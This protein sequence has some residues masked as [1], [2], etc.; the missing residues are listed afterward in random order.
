MS[1]H[2]NHYEPTGSLTISR[3]IITAFT[4]MTFFTAIPLVSAVYESHLLKINMD[5]GIVGKWFIFWAVAVRFLVTGFLQVLRQG[6]GRSVVLTQSNSGQNMAKM[7]GLVKMFLAG[8]AFLCVVKGSGSLLAAI[9]AGIY[10]GLAAFQH[11]FKRPATIEGWIEMIFDM[12]VFIVISCC[13]V[14]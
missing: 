11:D 7:E 13:L 14:F 6:K 10:I 8:L 4:N 9:I 3:Q 12:L 5:A 1:L 2:T